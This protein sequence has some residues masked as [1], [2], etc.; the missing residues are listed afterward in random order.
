INPGAALWFLMVPIFDAVS[1]M[2]RRIL[3]KRSPF[4]A[5]KE[6]LHHVFLFAGFSVGETVFIMSG[7]ALAGIF[8]G[9]GGMF[10]G[11]S[12]LVMVLAFFILGMLYFWVI[13]RAWKVMKFL[14]RSICRRQL[15]HNSTYSLS[16]RRQNR[17]SNYSGPERRSGIDR[18]K[19]PAEY[20]KITE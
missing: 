17:N 16:D 7:I 13:M 8:V 12:D 4:S 10:L 2:I 11:I 9:L 18:R 5:D 6:H 20:K 3:H 19:Q 15:A 1:M 14:R